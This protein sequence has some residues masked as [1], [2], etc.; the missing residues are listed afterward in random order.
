MWIKH[1]LQIFKFTARPVRPK[2]AATTRTVLSL[3]GYMPVPP[4]VG[5]LRMLDF[6]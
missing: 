4:A 1:K 3:L 5:V 6:C 2:L